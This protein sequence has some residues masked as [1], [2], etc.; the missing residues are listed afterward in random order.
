MVGHQ[1][2]NL[3]IGVRVPASQPIMPVVLTCRSLALDDHCAARQRWSD[4]EMRLTCCG[5]PRGARVKSP[6]RQPIEPAR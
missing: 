4:W 6:T 1:T 5:K 3:A 2:L